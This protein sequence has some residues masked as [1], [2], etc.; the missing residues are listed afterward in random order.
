DA[1]RWLVS[2]GIGRVDQLAIAGWSYGGYAAL[3]SQVLDPG[4]FKAVVAIAPVTDLSYVIEDAR[5]YTNFKVVRDF[6]GTGPH[7]AA[8]SPRRHA[9]RFVAPVALFHGTLDLNVDVRHARGMESALKSAG[10]QVL[11]R[12]YPDL[13]H[14]LGDSAVRTAMLTDIGRF[15][16]TTLGRD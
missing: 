15:L 2:E 3:Q 5:D 14:G 8:G 4:L 12:E 11:Y 10:K 13:Q 9:E 1:G 7:L 6:I 16:D